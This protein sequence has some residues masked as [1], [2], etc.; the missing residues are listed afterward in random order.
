MSRAFVKESEEGADGAD[1]PERAVSPHRNL[2]TATGLAQI[3]GT[4][5]RLEAELAAARAAA[6]KGAIAWCQ[7]DLRYWHRRRAT[8]ET[9]ATP[10]GGERVRFGS[11]V[12]LRMDDGSARRLRIV[13]EDEADPAAGAIA[14]VAP[15]AAA[16][17]GKEPGDRVATGAG[18]GE[19]LAIG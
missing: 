4:V 3:A 10:P 15:V 5:R 16:M 11:T 9:V 18:E 12:T 6:D 14:Y 19:I 13:G 8:A 2:V 7:R 17:I 1:L